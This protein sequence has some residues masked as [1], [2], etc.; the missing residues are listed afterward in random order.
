MIIEESQVR[1]PSRKYTLTVHCIKTRRL[2]AIEWLILSCISKFH[3][4]STMSDSKMR[5]AFESVFGLQDSDLLIKPSLDEL[6]KIGVIQWTGAFDYSRVTFGSVQL[7]AL[8]IQMLDT[9]LLPGDNT[10]I[11]LVI[12]YNPLTGRIN[13]QEIQK[14][15]VSD[16]IVFGSLA[17]YGTYFPEEEIKQSLQSGEVG[18]NRF[19]A[20]EYIIQS[21]ENTNTQQSETFTTLKLDLD[22]SDVLSIAPR[23][24]NAN[25]QKQV[26]KLLF[27]KEMDKQFVQSLVLRSGMEIELVY[28]TGKRI[29]KAI[30]AVCKNGH[31]LFVDE[32]FFLFYSKIDSTLFEGK[33]LILYNAQRLESYMYRN[34][35]VMTIPVG[36][37]FPGC[38]VIN[39]KNESVS[40]CKSVLS[41]EGQKIEYPLALKD[42]RVSRKNGILK[43]FEEA[44]IRKGKR[45]VA[46]YGLASCPLLSCRAS[47]IY[48]DLIASWKTKTLDAIL[49]DVAQI[50]RLPSAV[51][52]TGFDI[53]KVSELLIG[54]ISSKNAEQTLI[55]CQRIIA[56]P[57][58][59]AK[60]HLHRLLVEKALSIAKKPTTYNELQALQ[61]R[62]GVK[63]HD[64]AL[65]FDDLFDSLYDE[66][67]VRDI[68]ARVMKGENP[69][70]REF[71]AADE[72]FNTYIANLNDISFLVGKI[73]LFAKQEEKAFRNTVTNC[74][75]MAL[76]QMQVAELSSKNAELVKHSINIYALMTQID[77]V[78]C[79]RFYYNLGLIDRFIVEKIKGIIPVDTDNDKKPNGKTVVAKIE[80]KVFVLDTSAIIHNPDLFLYFSAN[81]YVRLPLVVLA[82]LGKIKDR[83]SDLFERTDDS[84]TTARFLAKDIRN[85]YLKCF[86]VMNECILMTEVSALD[87]LPPDLD[88]TTPDHQ[89]LSV[90]LKYKNWDV[91][92]ITDD[93]QFSLIAE[94]IGIKTISS[95]EFIKTHKSYYCDKKWL[96]EKYEG[97]DMP[98]TMVRDWLVN[99][100]EVETTTIVSR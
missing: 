73:N 88:Q 90:A 10:D 24:I 20:S 45:D 99:N 30:S 65:I 46:Y 13:S 41:F 27:P 17:D 14:G 57:G 23:I 52:L 76:L 53:E 72:Y 5:D 38:V 54:K 33:I 51:H 31:F 84:S 62:M 60:S 36:L 68:L 92:L 16:T 91:C 78:K 35:T 44:I 70:S 1:V 3:N 26:E 94:Q 11:P 83:R 67:V 82:E 42:R 40:I 77:P 22:S 15:P 93:L 75:D 48:T 7:T 19:S 87:L 21:I 55:D 4:S 79:E 74:P 34:S 71:F 28:G 8:G 69:I 96:K 66:T 61:D 58:L 86:N 37:D 97:S 49:S 12:W 50:T 63:D 39:E 18:T 25:M 6:K 59:V 64:T 47:G 29:K 81:E 43:W 100:A 85:I 80:E 95:N 9:G 89:I 32:S 2:T 56:S 98:S